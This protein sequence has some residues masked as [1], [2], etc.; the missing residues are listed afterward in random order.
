MSDQSAYRSDD[1]ADIALIGDLLARLAILAD[2]GDIDEYVACFTRDAVWRLP[3]IAATGVAATEVVGRDAIATAARGRR[4]DGV[5]GP[6]TATRHIVTGAAIIVDGL[7]ARGRS[8]FRFYTHT[9][10]EPRLV[11]MGVYRDVFEKVDGGWL[12]AERTI[13]VG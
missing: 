2:E 10:A 6:G 5:Q 12:L 11:T 1:A 9:T 4:A 8:Y 7:H 13:T 3:A